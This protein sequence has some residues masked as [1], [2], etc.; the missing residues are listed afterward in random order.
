MLIREKRMEIFKV[1]N[2]LDTKSLD[3]NGFKFD[4]FE[5]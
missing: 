2:F 4:I 5:H 1:P 3:Q